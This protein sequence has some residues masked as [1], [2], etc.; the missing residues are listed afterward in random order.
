MITWMAIEACFLG[1]VLFLCY[2]AISLNNEQNKVLVQQSKD[3]AELQLQNY[4]LLEATTF[5]ADKMTNIV[6]VI[7]EK[8][9]WDK[10]VAEKIR[11]IDEFNRTT[12][13]LLIGYTNENAKAVP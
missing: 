4:R 5:L 9:E 8:A 3:I 7:A 10:R 2:S 1:L 6:G 11:Q 13:L 12:A